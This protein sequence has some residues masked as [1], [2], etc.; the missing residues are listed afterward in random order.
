MLFDEDGATHLP[1][2]MVEGEID[3]VGAGDSVTAGI[4]SALCAGATHVEAGLIGNLVAS[5]TIQRIGATGTASPEQV[6]TRH[7]RET[8]L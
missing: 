3:I 7:A 4:V 6:L 1:G 8:A 5:I 2:V